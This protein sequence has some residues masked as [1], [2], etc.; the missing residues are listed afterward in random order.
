MNWF[1]NS[2]SEWNFSDRF[3]KRS[4]TWLTKLSC[5]F[6]TL[7]TSTESYFFRILSWRRKYNLDHSI[8]KWSFSTVSI[9]THNHECSSI[10]LS[11]LFSTMRHSTRLRRWNLKWDSFLFIRFLFKC[12]F[13]MSIEFV[14]SFWWRKLSN[15]FFFD[16]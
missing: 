1:S 12:L 11:T 7:T 9:S 10:S 3:T 15:L 6:A 16:D 2:F 4:K 13:L 8:S 5:L 14:T